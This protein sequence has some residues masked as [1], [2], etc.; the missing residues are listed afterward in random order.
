MRKQTIGLTLAL[1]AWCAMAAP[2]HA[3]NFE[4]ITN[5]SWNKRAEIIDV[6]L[7]NTD[8][9]TKEPVAIMRKKVL[10]LPTDTV[11]FRLPIRGRVVGVDAYCVR[12]DPD[13]RRIP[14]TTVDVNAVCDRGMID[15]PLVAGEDYRR[16]FN[17]YR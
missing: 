11:A 7:F 8:V 2:V 13:R 14:N 4:I 16:M 9:S 3:A 12:Y 6:W 1:T 5:T 15:D 17:Y 10:N